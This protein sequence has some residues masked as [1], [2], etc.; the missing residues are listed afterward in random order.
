MIFT[1]PY[2]AARA[3]QA[4]RATG[5]GSSFGARSGRSAALTAAPTALAAI[6]AAQPLKGRAQS[7]S[8]SGI[9]RR[10]AVPS[11]LGGFA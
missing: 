7:A 9:D 1:V 4:A 6:L 3:L 5:P 8:R 11:R 2:G 10:M